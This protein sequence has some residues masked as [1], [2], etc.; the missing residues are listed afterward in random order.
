MKRPTVIDISEQLREAA[1]SRAGVS[2]SVSAQGLLSHSGNEL[3][4]TATI[5]VY[6]GRGVGLCIHLGDSFALCCLTDVAAF[7]LAQALIN[8]SAYE[9]I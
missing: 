5:E 9:F 8:G 4:G 3:E 2:V 7:A 6:S 1:A